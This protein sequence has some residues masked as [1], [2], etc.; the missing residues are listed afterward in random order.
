M[1]LNEAI[2]A[3]VENHA[4]E[5]AAKKKADAAKKIILAACGELDELKTDIWTVYIKRTPSM[6]LNLEELYKDFP[7][8]KE[9]Y[10]KESIRT[11]IDA[12]CIAA[13]ATKTA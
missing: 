9:L 5:S 4:I 1:S 11:S 6:G 8:I 2:A 13:S 12:H 3:Y 10:P 7:D